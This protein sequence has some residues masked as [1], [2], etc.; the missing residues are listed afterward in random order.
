VKGIAIYAEGGGDHPGPELRVGLDTLLKA[1]KEA[2]RERRVRWSMVLCG[3][4]QRTCDAFLD[5]V[6]KEPDVV[7]VLLVDS[8]GPVAAETGDVQ[9]DAVAR[10]QHLKT[11]DG[12]NLD[13]VDAERIHLMV[14]CM[15][16]WIVADPD[17]LASFY[18]QYFNAKALPARKNLEEEPKQDLY[19][20]LDKAT[21]DKRL[22]KG[23]YGKIRHASELLKRIDP[24]K[25][26][27]RCPRFATFTRWLDATI[28]GP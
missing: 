6:Y 14:Q 4:R 18:G 11:R 20:K 28:V 10:R 3:D 25:V 1:Q 8:E 23:S 21:G 27:V 24:A 16:A 5:A 19:D 26:A 15:E 22:T 2:A 9:K 17:A 12:W 7:N 13:A